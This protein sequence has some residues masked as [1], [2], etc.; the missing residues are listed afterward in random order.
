VGEIHF[1]GLPEDKFIEEALSIVEKAKG[2]GIQLRLIGALAIYIHSDNCPICREKFRTL[3]RFGEGQPLFTDLDLVG[4]GKQRKDIK[5][6]FEQTLKFKPDFYI[7]RLFGTRRHIYYHP[8]GYYHVDVFFDK[9]EFSHDV[10]LKKRLELDYP[11]I[12]LADLVLEKTQIHEINRKDIVDLIVLFLGHEVGEKQEKEI[13]DG[14][15]IA[16]VL[17]DDWGFYYDATNNLK[18]VKRFSE[19]FVKEGKLSEEECKTVVERVDKLLEM[20]EAEPKT[21]KWRKRAKVGT[22]KPWYRVVEEVVR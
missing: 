4:Y 17:A 20:I 6:L 5:K 13:I 12:S 2:M 15:Y 10:D 14:K 18:L 21:R 9:L 19:S 3:G 8:Q 7:N 22:K 1:V 16:K 11:T